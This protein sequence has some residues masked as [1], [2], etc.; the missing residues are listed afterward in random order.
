MKD[1]AGDWGFRALIVPKPELLT[2][3]KKIWRTHTLR[4][5]QKAIEAFLHAISVNKVLFFIE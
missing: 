5:K 4:Q 3:D 1:P 2:V